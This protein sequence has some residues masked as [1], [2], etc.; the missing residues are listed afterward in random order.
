[1]VF[2]RFIKA[3]QLTLRSLLQKFFQKIVAKLSM[4]VNIFMRSPQILVFF[5]PQL[6]S[7]IG[8]FNFMHKTLLIHLIYIS[9]SYLP[10]LVLRIIFT[11]KSDS[12]EL[13]RKRN[14]RKN[15]FSSQLAKCL[16]QTVVVL[17]TYLVSIHTKSTHIRS[18]IGSSIESLKTPQILIYYQVL[19][20]FSEQGDVC[21]SMKRNSQSFISW[22]I[23][24]G[25]KRSVDVMLP[26]KMNWICSCVLWI[27]Q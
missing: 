14:I 2:F 26:V 22:E 1:M 15:V 11:R 7:L 24:I 17:I 10:L 19:I 20:A 27:Y 16:N 9:Q 8:C 12:I 13:D 3:R 5:I 6:F 25:I 4:V 23:K 18:R 21:Q